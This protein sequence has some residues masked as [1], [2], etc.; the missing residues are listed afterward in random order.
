MNKHDTIVLAAKVANRLAPQS[1][2]LQ[3]ICREG[4][5]IH[6][7]PNALLDREAHASLAEPEA[8]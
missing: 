1:W 3:P 6:D 8:E 5:P 7:H 4:H 2:R